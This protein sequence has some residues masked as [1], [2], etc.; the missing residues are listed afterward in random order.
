MGR[1]RHPCYGA[2]RPHSRVPRLHTLIAHARIRHL[3]W[4][5]LAMPNIDGNRPLWRH[6]NQRWRP[7][8]YAPPCV[9]VCARLQVGTSADSG[10]VLVMQAADQMGNLCTRGGA[11]VA[12]KLLQS[13]TDQ[14]PI[15]YGVTDNGD[16]TYTM[17]WRSKFSGD[18]QSQI[19]ID[20]KPVRGSPVVFKL[21]STNP[22]LSKSELDCD[23]LRSATAGQVMTLRIRFFDS[24]GNLAV[25]G[26]DFKFGIAMSSELKKKI[27]DVRPAENTVEWLAPETGEC[28]LKFQ[29][30]TA[31]NQELHVWSDPQVC[32]VW[33]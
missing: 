25:P 26:D 6:V 19:T 11:N 14:R 12:L 22:E 29:P 17:N 10:C 5:A 4:P 16:G 20:G 8:C 31:G 21:Q 24:Y 27:N 23:G 33:L 2:H 7:P 28:S 9:H 30:T 32:G 3:V 15:E 18:A 1:P 13:K